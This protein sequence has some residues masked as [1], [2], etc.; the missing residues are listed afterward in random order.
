MCRLE[1]FKELTK[2]EKLNRRKRFE[3]KLKQQDFYDNIEELFYPATDTLNP[4]TDADSKLALSASNQTLRA[5]NWQNQ[6]LDK[7]TM[8]IEEA[9]SLISETASQID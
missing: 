8:A 9:G 7:Q 1:I 6:D 3:D 2:P 4:V 5:L